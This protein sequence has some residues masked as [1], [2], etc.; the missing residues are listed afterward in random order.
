MLYRRQRIGE[1]EVYEFGAELDGGDDLHE[2]WRKATA[3]D[4][5]FLSRAVANSN[6]ELEQLR[7]PF[8]WFTDTFFSLTGGMSH[9]QQ[10]IQ[11][12]LEKHPW[13]A[14]E[15]VA[16]LRDVDVPITSIR[17]ESILGESESVRPD[18]AELGAL[19]SL[20]ALGAKRPRRRTTLTHT[21][22]LGSAEFDFSEESEGT[23]N[24]P[25]R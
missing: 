1:S 11:P 9:W 12:L 16:L 4:V 24:H 6:E 17:S 15:V 10:S 7:H 20:L 21:T 14:D 2:T 5:L 19:S 3:P 8:H 23:K 13:F 25:F 18:I 22:E